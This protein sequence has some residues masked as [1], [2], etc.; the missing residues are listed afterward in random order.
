MVASLLKHRVSG[1]CLTQVTICSILAGATFSDEGFAA[2]SGRRV[3]DGCT[4]VAVIDELSFGFC[5]GR[6][7]LG[8]VSWRK[9]CWSAG[10]LGPQAVRVSVKGRESGKFGSLG[11]QGSL[12]GG[13]QTSSLSIESFLQS[14]IGTVQDPFNRNTCNTAT[15]C[16]PKPLYR[17]SNMRDRHPRAPEHVVDQKDR[18][19]S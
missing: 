17:P 1:D 2:G 7:G 13:A 5:P 10:L 11:H 4:R 14:T 12:P 16:P 8:L 15:A 3:R 6:S 19:V 18:R 9:H